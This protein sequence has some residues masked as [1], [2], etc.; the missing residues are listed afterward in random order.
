MEINNFAIW[1]FLSSTQHDE[2][3]QTIR[4]DRKSTTKYIIIVILCV[5]LK[6]ILRSALWRVGFSSQE[7]K[8]GK[9]K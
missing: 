8:V 2:G 4:K 5:I 6:V 7:N 1:K 3:K 9:R